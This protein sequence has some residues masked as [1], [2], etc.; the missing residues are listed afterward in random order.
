MPILQTGQADTITEG[1]RA[2]KLFTDR[3]EAIR[4]FSAYLN[5]DPPRERIL[6]FYGDGGNGKSLLLRF[7]REH[8]CKR[9]RPDNWE[10]VKTLPDEKFA[11]HI[12]NAEGT[13][14]VPFAHL[15]FGM[16]SRGDD[17]PQEAFSGLLMLR[18]ALAGHGLRFPLYDFACVWYLHK[19]GKLTDERLKSLFP[20]E[21]MDF[22]TG[23]VDA[24][25]RTSWGALGKAVL[26]VFG[27][28]LR[29][30]FT[31][32][33]QRRKLDEAQVEAIQRMDPES[34]LMDQLPHL[35]A[36]DLNTAMSLEGAPKR[37][38]LFFDTHEAFWG[39]QRNLSDD[40]FFQRDEWLRR[41]L[42]TL[43]L[44][45]GIV[46][47][48]AGRDRP[49]WAEASKF[50]IPEE[51]LDIQLVGHLSEADAAQY[52]ERAGVADATM[53]QC[54]VDYAR[55]APDQIHPFYLGL[56]ADVALAASEKG[57]TLTPED[58]RIAPQVADKG[59]ELMNRLLRYVD[60]EVGYAVRA[61]SACR[62]FDREIYFKLGDALNFQATEPAFG[63]LTRFSFVWLVEQRG[64]GWYRIHDLLRRLARERG[65]EI[66]H[67]ADEVLE[68]HYRERGEVGETLT[69]AEAIYHANRLDWERGVN[70]W[71][72]VFDDALK[73]SNYGICRPLL[74]VRNELSIETDFWRGLVSQYEG[75]YFASLARY[76]EARREYLE[77]IAAYDEALKRASDDVYAHN[78]KGNA[79]LGLGDLQTELSQHEE[80][81]ESYMQAIAAYNEALRRVP[82]DVTAHNNKGNALQSLGELQA[83]LAQHPE[84][85]E[86]YTKAIAAFDKVL[87]YAPDDVYAYNNKGNTFQSL[88][89]LQAK[90]SQYKEAVESYM[91]AISAYDETLGRT[92]DLVPAHNNKGNALQSL[93]QLQ[94]E[95]SQHKE[96]IES[97]MKAIAAYDEALGCAPDFVAAYN[98]KGNA[99]TRLG[100]LQAE[101]SQYK[102][103]L[104]SYKQAIAAYNDA[105]GR[106]P[107]YVPVHTSKGNVLQ[108]LG[109]LQAG[110]SQYEEAVES[111]T[112]AIVTCDEVLRRAPNYVAAHNNKGNA[113][114]YLGELQAKLSQHKEA[115]SSYTKAISAYDDALGRAPD[116]V[117]AHN[118]KGNAL[119]K[120]GELQAELLQ[121]KEAVSSYTK[122]ISAYD[123][124]LGRAPDDVYAYN[125]KGNAFLR[126]GQLQAELLQHKEAA[127]SYTKAI[128]AYDD[129]LGHAPDDV[130][131]YNNKGNAFLRL[132]QLQA[133]LL[134]HKEAASSYRQ[135]ISAFDEALGCAPDLVQTHNNKG[136]TFA[137]LGN[138]QVELSQ[139]EEAV[140][141]YK[142]AI[143]VY[144]EAL[145][146]APDDVVTHNNKGLTL[147]S[148]GGLQFKLLQREKAIES[149]QVALVEFSQ[150]LEIAPGDRRIR[151]LKDRGQRMINELRGRE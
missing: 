26:N 91:K 4:L 131:A 110:L 113:L 30:R 98:N 75:N 78:N 23:I 13:E 49:R 38:A 105:L 77:A 96:A 121:H 80:A 135:A 114:Q 147:L 35:F 94:V 3:C 14:P 8:C 134:Q 92:P 149:L 117:L 51:Y 43:E 74:E 102:E 109:E 46:A 130:Y 50:K 58:F 148:L 141:S 5:D 72:T 90:L 125:N 53:R 139:H 7:L 47:V 146:R 142:K 1:W 133:E 15:D 86:S 59:T 45:A 42:G 27:K 145:R 119:Q 70:E 89:Q 120:L 22:I 66:A 31:L 101:L 122:A 62:A 84:A 111:Y 73:L 128:S 76:N 88:G 151:D 37:I 68:K 85:A 34:E 81:A 10:W 83:I 36:D 106:A 97:Y 52:L 48:V 140:E 137:S 104:S 40:I 112:K 61:L 18:R 44:S 64:E 41:L 115:V 127:S 39:S 116:D 60:S 11:E 63:V 21:E 99:L 12:K 150:S 71:V 55:V 32:Y 16:P 19:T 17:R 103:A 93:G 79:F 56:C 29:Q 107:D 124:A 28:H 95:L 129:A 100:D 143:A 6:F 20:A 69:V 118:N 87:E 54:L 33:M 138:L 82:D 67:R 132:G 2:L 136:L 24:I 25:S 126:L 144:D 65:D 9:L 57:T 123:D 108:R